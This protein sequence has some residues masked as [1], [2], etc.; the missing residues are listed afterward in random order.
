MCRGDGRRE[1]RKTYTCPFYT[2]GPTGCSIHPDWK[3]YG[4]LAFNPR[5]PGVTSGGHC[6]SDQD[7]LLKR[8]TGGEAETNT[9]LREQHKL[10]WSTAP[11]PIALRDWWQ[12]QNDE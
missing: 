2:P 3:P 5:R 7:L 8:E 12:R 4:C 10:D 11:L 9:A 1:M 6:A